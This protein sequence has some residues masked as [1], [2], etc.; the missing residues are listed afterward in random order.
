[1]SCNDRFRILTPTLGIEVVEGERI[2]V[3]IPVDATVTVT[4]AQ[5]AEGLL[6][7]DWNGKSLLMYCH[8]LDE[9]AEAVRSAGSSAA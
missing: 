9:R 4:G 5:D 2:P 6:T 7:I 3:T 8:D 1:M